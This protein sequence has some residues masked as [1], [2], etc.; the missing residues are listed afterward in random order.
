MYIKRKIKE[1]QG[2]KAELAKMEPE[3]RL[4]IETKG[5]ITCT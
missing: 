3:L 2:T 1:N 4:K 5:E